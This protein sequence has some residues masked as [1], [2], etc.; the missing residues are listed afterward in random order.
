M[1]YLW[2]A[3]ALGLLISLSHNRLLVQASKPE[4][5]NQQHS[6]AGMA[7]DGAACMAFMPAWSYDPTKNACVDFI[8]GGCGG[9]SNQF[10]S[11][12]ECEKACKD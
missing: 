12:E 3:A 7:Q 9:N 8:F 6:M 1:K 5:C 2:L 10:K 11:Q 4:M